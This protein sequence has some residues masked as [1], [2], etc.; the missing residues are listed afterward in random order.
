MSDTNQTAAQG[1]DELRLFIAA[2]RLAADEAE[3]TAY[4]SA[5]TTTWWASRSPRPGADLGCWR[6]AG[7][8]VNPK[9]LAPLTADAKQRP[10]LARGLDQPLVRSEAAE[11][12]IAGGFHPSMRGRAPTEQRHRPR[13]TLH[14]Q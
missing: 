7:N 5:G 9:R 13:P 12:A 8:F 3:R 4:R 11:D 6:E 10:L 14:R 1:W 2:I